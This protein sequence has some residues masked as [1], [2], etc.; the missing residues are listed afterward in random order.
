MRSLAPN[1]NINLPRQKLE[2]LYSIFVLILVPSLMVINTLVISRAVRRNFDAELRHRADLANQI[3]GLSVVDKLNDA[4][5]IQQ[6][7]DNLAEVRD[8]IS[9]IVIVQPTDGQYKVIAALDRN[10]VGETISGITFNLAQEQEQSISRLAP[11]KRHP[12]E[13]SW[14]VVTPIKD[15]N[16]NL[17]AVFSMDLSLAAADQAISSTFSRSFAILFVTVFVVALLLSNHFRFVEYAQ[18][19]RKLQEADRLKTDFLSVATHELKAPMSAIKGHIANVLDGTFGEI[20]Q[21][22]RASLEEASKQTERLND[23][24]QDLLNV[25]RIE[26][27]RIRFEI[28]PV[29]LSDVI[30][31]IV[32]AYTDKAAA[33]G[34]SLEYRRPL[35]PQIALVDEGRVQEIF[36]NLIDNA[37]KYS[38]KGKIEI[39]HPPSQTRGRVL[40][41]VKDHGIGISAKERQRLFS[42]FYR[43]RNEQ[44]KNIGGTGLGLWIIKQ[45]IE[46]MGGNIYVDSLEGVGTEFTVELPAPKKG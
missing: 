19:T 37:V 11:D 45:Y 3:F 6:T 1:L 5:S 9:D 33:K 41:K 8:E 23:L 27:G 21:Q 10:L 42:R 18:L 17:A 4:N 29:N 44:T 15:V 22:T 24:V 12:G 32:N 28:K 39:Y 2:L 43:V 36:T 7:I 40:T 31:Q 30:S 25:S 13:R 14:N 20:N 16:G 34:L 26:Q 46:K 38:Q 35:Q